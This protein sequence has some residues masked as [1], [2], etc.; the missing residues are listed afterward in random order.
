MHDHGSPVF[1]GPASGSALELAPGGYRPLPDEESASPF[2]TWLEQLGL[3]H[4]E[5]R[6]GWHI[7]CAPEAPICAGSWTS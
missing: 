7:S 6:T 2:D 4:D 1:N 3:T 5:F